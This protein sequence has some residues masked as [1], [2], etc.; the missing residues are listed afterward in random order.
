M[1]KR[2]APGQ[3]VEVVWLDSGAD[4]HGSPKDRLLTC[5]PSRT[6]GV[7]VRLGPC[8]EL[9]RLVG[10]ILAERPGMTR[11]KKKTPDVL[12]LAHCSSGEDDESSHLGAVTWD[13]VLSWRVLT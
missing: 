7:V 5:Y 1:A 9:E 11:T 8:A 6:L 10:E 12:V 4:H 3:V 2:P 13:S